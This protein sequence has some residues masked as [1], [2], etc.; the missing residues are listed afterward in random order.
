[1]LPQLLR[2]HVAVRTHMVDLFVRINLAAVNLPQGTACAEMLGSDRTRR[3]RATFKGRQTSRT[4]GRTGATIWRT[5]AVSVFRYP[6][7]AWCCAVQL[8]RSCSCGG[9]TFIA[10]IMYCCFVLLSFVFR[11]SNLFSRSVRTVCLSLSLVDFPFA[12][13]VYEQCP[14][15]L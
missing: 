11:S 6:F 7:R 9:G 8:A 1:M 14:R 12:L 2:S 13:A 10:T 4:S 15:C 5:Q 3:L